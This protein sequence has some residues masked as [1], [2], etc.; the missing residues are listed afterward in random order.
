MLCTRNVMHLS[1]SAGTPLSPRTPRASILACA[2]QVTLPSWMPCSAATACTLRLRLCQ[3]FCT[4]YSQQ[5]VGT[6]YLHSLLTRLQCRALPA[7]SDA[8]CAPTSEPRKWATGPGAESWPPRYVGW[9]IVMEWLPCTQTVD[10]RSELAV[11]LQMAQSA[12]S[13][14]V[15]MCN[16]VQSELAAGTLRCSKRASNAIAGGC[17]EVRASVCILGN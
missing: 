6:W 2:C 7:C 5:A 15:C 17:A 9:S 3:F 8:C 16:R 10:A 4:I 13:G 1:N 12:W 11:M 14:T